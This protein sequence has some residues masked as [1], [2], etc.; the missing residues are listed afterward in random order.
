MLEKWDFQTFNLKDFRDFL[1]VCTS[2]VQNVERPKA[3]LKEH[4]IDKA[5]DLNQRQ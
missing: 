5:F 2:S 3:Q 1:C 4:T